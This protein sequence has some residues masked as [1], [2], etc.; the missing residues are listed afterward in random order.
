MHS[1]VETCRGDIMS[2][3]YDFQFVVFLTKRFVV[4]RVAYMKMHSMS[5]IQFKKPVCFANEKTIKK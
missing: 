3:C 1:G 4:Q 5:S 2:C